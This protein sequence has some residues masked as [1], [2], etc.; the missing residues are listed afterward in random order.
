V[1]VDGGPAGASTSFAPNASP[2]YVSTST[3]NNWLAVAIALAV[4]ALVLGLLVLFLSRRKEP[5]GAAVP[6]TPPQPPLPAKGGAAPPP[7][8]GS[9]SWSEGPPPPAGGT[10]PG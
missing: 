7:G 6:W 2:S 8:E 1:T 4:I 10:P 9:A 5:H 3:F